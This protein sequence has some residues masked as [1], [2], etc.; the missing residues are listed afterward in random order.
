MNNIRC[1]TNTQHLADLK[2][3]LGTMWSSTRVAESTTGY[4]WCEKEVLYIERSNL[5]CL[6]IEIRSHIIFGG[7]LKFKV[8]KLGS[9]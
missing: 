2:F 3:I 7:V 6:T 4:F 8:F 9:F 1:Y 5:R